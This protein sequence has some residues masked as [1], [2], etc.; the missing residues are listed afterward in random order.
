MVAATHDFL[1][2]S[3]LHV[4]KYLV[5]PNFDLETDYIFGMPMNRHFQQYIVH[6]EILSTFQARIK[7]ISVKNTSFK[8]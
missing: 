1:V 7:Y 2:K 3:L 8:Q 4:C 6:R 5:N